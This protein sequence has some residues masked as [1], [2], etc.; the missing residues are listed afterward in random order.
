MLYGRAKTCCHIN[1]SA[2]GDGWEPRIWRG[3]QQPQAAAQRPKGEHEMPISDDSPDAHAFWH[4][5]HLAMFTGLCCFWR[6]DGSLVFSCFSP[7]LC[8]LMLI[9]LAVIFQIA[10]FLSC[11]AF[12]PDCLLFKRAL[13]HF[14]PLGIASLTHAHRF[15]LDTEITGSV[16]LLLD[17]VAR[18]PLLN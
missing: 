17:L 18:I 3:G 14:S 2:W 4:C 12:A 15:L 7:P 1:M 8:P 6:R 11:F 13:C 10:L 9:Y 5:M 16:S